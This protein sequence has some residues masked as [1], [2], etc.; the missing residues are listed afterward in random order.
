[1]QTTLKRYIRNVETKQPRGVAVAI[2]NNDEVRYGFS[3]LNTNMDKF[4]RELGLK[5]ATNR[6][7]SESYS[8]PDVPDRT[9]MVLDAFNHLEKRALKYF[10]DINPDKIILMP[11]NV[12]S[13][14]TE[15]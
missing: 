3:L 4:D 9:L 14:F 1:M 10:K 2:R 7:L 6:A 8:L 5:I 12:E 13:P 11:S 15:E